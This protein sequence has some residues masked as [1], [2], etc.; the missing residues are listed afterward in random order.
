MLYEIEIVFLHSTLSVK[1]AVNSGD[2]GNRTTAS[3]RHR[4]FRPLSCRMYISP[5][6]GSSLWGT[7][8]LSREMDP[9][10]QRGPGTRDQGLGIPNPKS[11]RAA[12]A[13]QPDHLELRT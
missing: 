11:E 9:K 2:K 7:I 6:F 10:S 12:I 3:T 4:G 8:R 13:A 5:L 1:R